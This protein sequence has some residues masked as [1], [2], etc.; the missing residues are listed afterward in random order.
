MWNRIRALVWKEFLQ[1]RRDRLTL[2]MLLFIP[3]IQITIYGFAHP[4]PGRVRLRGPGLPADRAGHR[5]ADR[6]RRHLRA[7]GLADASN[8]RSSK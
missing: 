6:A 4:R 7:I 3:L 2:V 1:L 8:T 5:R